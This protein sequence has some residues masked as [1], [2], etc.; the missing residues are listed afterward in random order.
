MPALSNQ[1]HTHF[2]KI[3][4]PAILVIFASFSNISSSAIYNITINKI[5]N[6]NDY[7]VQVNLSGFR[8]EDSVR[9][10]NGLNVSTSKKGGWKAKNL[11][12]TG[13][14][15]THQKVRVSFF[16]GTHVY[17]VQTK[18]TPDFRIGCNNSDKGPFETSSK[19]ITFTYTC[20]RINNESPSGSPSGSPS[21]VQDKF[22]NGAPYFNGYEDGI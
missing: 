15:G 14:E 1:K 5:E 2:R 10:V 18:I 9:I 6:K 4:A 21:D 12:M 7:P 11:T 22:N 8:N 3:I 16:T 17:R 19:K 13:A 20:T